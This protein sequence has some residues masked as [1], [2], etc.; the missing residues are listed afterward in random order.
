[1]YRAH[2]FRLDRSVAIKIIAGGADVGAERRE[3]FSREAQAVARLDHAH[4][5]RVYDVGRDRDL[6]YLVMEYLEGETLASRMAGGALPVGSAIEIAT[7]MADALAHIHQHRLVHRDLKPGNVMLTAGGAK[8]LD[9]GLAK[10]LA[11]ADRGV[12]V[13]G[14]TL[15][16]VGVIGGTLQYMAPEQIDGKP[17]DG[18]C[19]IF[20]LG[21]ILYE[22]LA[23]RPA[24][25]KET[26]SETVAGILG[27]QPVS[28]QALVPSL[29]PALA[30]VV[31]TCLAKRPADRF[32]SALQVAGALRQLD[33][34]PQA[35][36]ATGSGMTR[37]LRAR[38][39]WVALVLAAVA[40]VTGLFVTR[41]GTR[42]EIMPTVPVTA[43]APRRS[44]AV[45][46]FRNLSGRPDT[47][48]LSTALAEMLTS[49]LTAGEQIRAIAG[50]NIARMKIELKL[51]ETDGY[52]RDTLARIRRNV[53]SDLVVVGSYVMH[54]ALD[55]RK[56][57]LDLRVQDTRAG[58]TVASV[59]ETGSERDLLDLVSRVGGRVRNEL[60]MTVLS[61]SQS[62][63]VRSTVPSMWSLYGA[64]CSSSSSS[65][66]VA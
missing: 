43:S 32:Q 16:G 60:G 5:C 45:L 24:F 22:M 41:R 31:A 29:S 57:R 4:V 33:A 63:G 66:V 28:L 3:R 36:A 53:G 25:A 14:S 55:E 37:W 20:A 6:D 35:R 46:G 65:P 26:P 12:D 44:I 7:Q 30:D 1:V 49:E 51:I 27:A 50:E 48:W 34:T 58:E 38:G 61:P 17:V 40:V 2:D 59:S 42:V 62:A 52:A 39:A 8:L 19:D 18:R 56:V 15:I 9:F 10:S 47:A 23:G 21:V 13:T 54:G 64:Q 11:G